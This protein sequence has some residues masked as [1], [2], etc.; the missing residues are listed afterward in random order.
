MD[1]I[2]FL[3]QVPGTSRVDIDE[4]TGTLKRQGV[5]SKMNPYDLYAL[6]TALRIKAAHGGRVTALSM[7]PGQAE[8]ILREAFAMGADSAVLLSDP[9]FAGSDVLATS[10]ALSQAVMKLGG[11]D[12]IICG[13]QTTDG[14][15]AQVGPETAE[16]LNIPHASNVT[17][18]INVSDAII[19]KTDMGDSVQTIEMPFPCLIA[20]EKGVY[21]PRLPSYKLKLEAADRKITVLKLA[22][23]FDNDPGNYGL[24]GSPTRVERIFPPE[25]STEKIRI[26]GSGD[27]VA[28]LLYAKL[29]ELKFI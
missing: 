16:F 1:I 18:I 22:D 28:G 17:E 25:P 2:V 26:S 4:K 21:T 3:K 19:L 13:K 6:E 20:V 9:A 24:D 12:L 11:Y 5:E 29:K 27:E 7:G 10:R 23:L 8:A 15:T 14:D